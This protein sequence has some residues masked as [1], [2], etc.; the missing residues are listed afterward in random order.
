ML[1]ISHFS[2]EGTYGIL[3]IGG[4]KPFSRAYP[5]ESGN[6]HEEEKIRKE[7]VRGDQNGAKRD[8]VL[9]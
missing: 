6:T 8:I 1:F 7:G 9:T 2:E 4:L 5:Q 3:N